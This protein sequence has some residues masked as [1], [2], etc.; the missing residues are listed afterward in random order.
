[1]LTLQ[2]IF[3]T[4]LFE[5]VTMFKTLKSKFAM[6]Y[7]FLVVIIGIIGITATFTTY[8][9][10]NLLDGLIVD[11]YKSIRAS[12]DMSEALDA[13]NASILTYINISHEEGINSFFLYKNEFDDFF[14]MEASNIT[15]HG[16]KTLV[17]KINIDYPIYLEQF[18]KLQEIYASKG[19]NASIEYY[20]S[21]IVPQ[22]EKL[23]YA[24]SNIEALN[25]K[26]M[27][28]NKDIVTNYAKK[29]MYVALILSTFSVILG[30]L[31]SRLS[32]NRFLRP[33]YS[34]IDTMKTVKEGQLN[35]PAPIISNDELGELTIEFNNMTKRLNTFEQSTLGKLMAEKNKS[36]TIVKSISDP[37][38]VLD[39][40]YKITLLNNACEEVFNIKEED[41][42]NKYFLEAITN[43]DLYEYISHIFEAKDIQPETKIIYLNLKNKDYY[44][45]VI[46]SVLKDISSKPTGT[47]VLFQNVTQLKQIEKIKS[48]FTATIS[49]EF[50]TPLTSI[51]IGTSLIS[52]EKLGILNKKQ[53]QIIEAIVED[54]D[55][56]LALVNNL[57]I[58]SKIES[59]NS[60]FN[61]QPVLISEIIRGSMKCFLG[62]VKSKGIKLS[63]SPESADGRVKVDGEKITWVLNNLIS[64]AIKFTSPGD[65]IIVSTFIKHNKM[66]ISVKDTGI[67]I[68]SE[69]VEKIF[70]KF[71]QVPDKDSETKGTGLGLAI[72]KELIEA[73][74]GEIWC[75]SR[76]HMGSNFTFILPLVLDSEEEI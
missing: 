6:V 12:N 68:P 32:L 19:L 62:Q 35:K 20:K 61:I 3:L 66:C 17:E 76:L 75:E 38:I 71:V 44:F 70:D 54:S 8:T 55:K 49:H 65:E 21:N 57:L 29:T 18:S 16:E 56:L 43:G 37:L 22:Y 42:L 33:V 72:A 15:E 14:N 60:I 7:I 25:E 2:L 46:V 40:N 51:I 34:L 69:Y 23:R 64:N 1:M 9:L 26:D 30:F 63:Y 24:L 48:D 41:V 59:D 31:I 4:T 45:N 11:N 39:P 50:K 74:G 5:E 13:Q 53:K 10:S 52:G 36:M 47:V 73:H 58:L 67:G 27:L 28:S